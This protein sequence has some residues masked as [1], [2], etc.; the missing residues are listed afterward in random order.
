MCQFHIGCCYFTN[1]IPEQLYSISALYSICN[2]NFQISNRKRRIFVFCVVNLPL[3]IKD[4]AERGGGE[5]EEE[6]RDII[7]DE[8]TNM[9]SARPRRMSEVKDEPEP[10]LPIPEGSSY[11]IMSQTNRCGSGPILKV[12]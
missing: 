10:I 2:G 6:T 1:E 3:K 11:F 7:E 8:G 12:L 9:V 5:D 4:Q